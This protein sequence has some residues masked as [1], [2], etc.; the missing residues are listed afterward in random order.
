MA[1]HTILLSLNVG[2]KFFCNLT[3]N[4]LTLNQFI[5]QISREQKTMAAI[6][7][8]RDNGLFRAFT[9]EE[10]HLEEFGIRRFIAFIDSVSSL[11]HKIT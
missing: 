11:R 1:P 9:P 10:Y 4:N 8:L 7:L 5:Q 6:R 3:V 2:V